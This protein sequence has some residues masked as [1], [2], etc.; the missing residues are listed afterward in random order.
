MS[1]EIEIIR[2][3]TEYSQKWDKFVEK[4]LMEHF[5]NQENSYPITLKTV[6]KTTPCYL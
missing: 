1:K 3:S 5:C 4:A 6:L 2:Y